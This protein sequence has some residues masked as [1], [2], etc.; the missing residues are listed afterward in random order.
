M[1]EEKWYGNI[2]RKEL[3][4]KDTWKDEFV[5]QSKEYFFSLRKC[6]R[7]QDKVLD[8]FKVDSELAKKR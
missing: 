1:L 4:L 8:C 6:K 2:K 7:S 5:R 3:F